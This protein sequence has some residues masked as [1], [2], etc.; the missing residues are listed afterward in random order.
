MKNIL[1]ACLLTTRYLVY[2]GNWVIGHNFVVKIL[3]IFYHFF[4]LNTFFLRFYNCDIE[5]LTTFILSAALRDKKKIV[6]TNI[7]IAVYSNNFSL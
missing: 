3:F 4:W 6:G 5:N 7:P 2:T 1:N